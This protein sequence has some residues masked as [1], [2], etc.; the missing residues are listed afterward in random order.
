MAEAKTLPSPVF[1][2]GSINSISA[3]GLTAVGGSD[4]HRP[5]T[6]LD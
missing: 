3:I 4:S 6:P 1:L 5:M 2:S